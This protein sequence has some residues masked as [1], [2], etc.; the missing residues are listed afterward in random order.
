MLFGI[1]AVA[2]LA[3]NMEVVTRNVRY[4]WSSVFYIMAGAEFFLWLWHSIFL[5]GSHSPY[6][7]HKDTFGLNRH[8]YNIVVDAATRGF[9]NRFMLYFF[10]LFML[11]ES[12][13]C[14]VTPLF[15]I[16]M[17]HNGGLGLA[18][19][20]FGLTFGTMGIIAIFIGSHI[21]NIAIRRY[22]MRRWMLPMAA[23]MSLHGLAMLYLSYNLSVSLAF[24]CLATFAGNLVLGF[25]SSAYQSAIA[26]FACRAAGGVFRQAIAMSL[27]SLTTIL[28]GIFSGLLQIN[29]GYRQFFIIAT[30]LY[31][32]TFVV[33]AVFTLVRKISQ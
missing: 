17:P 21:G 24:V 31:A 33:A 12:L 22:G 25:G 27:M 10:A 19:Q 18:P 16:D 26:S 15:F 14:L 13:M 2:M 11:P 28:T 32:I 9:H 20:E 6:I 7:K 29:I 1:G 23:V 3:G 5:P 8:E 4:S 30:G